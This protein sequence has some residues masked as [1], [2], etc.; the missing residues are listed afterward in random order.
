VRSCSNSPSWSK[1]C[2]PGP[3]RPRRHCHGPRLRVRGERRT[4]AFLPCRLGRT[5]PC[6]WSAASTCSGVSPGRPFLATSGQYDCRAG[7]RSTD[8]LRRYQESPPS[9]LPVVQESSRAGLSSRSRQQRLQWAVHPWPAQRCDGF[10]T[11]TGDTTTYCFELYPEIAD[12][13]IGESV[14]PS[15]S[16]VEA[17]D[18]QEPYINQALAVSSLAMLAR[19]LRYRQ[20]S[21]HGGFYNA[22]TG[23]MTRFQ[24]IQTI[25][26]KMREN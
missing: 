5:R 1:P 9:H 8:Q 15:C 4:S 21:Y 16:A 2:A 10:R 6:V 24:S 17:L 13:T 18:R 22:E 20:I 7:V 26:A 23:R 3:T 19:L 12:I 25:F 14:L 11:R